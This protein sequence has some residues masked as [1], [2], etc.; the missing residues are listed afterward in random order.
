MGLVGWGPEVLR[1]L[2][3]GEGGGAGGLSGTGRTDCWMDIL[4]FGQTI[5]NSHLYSNFCITGKPC[6]PDFL[7]FC[8]SSMEGHY[9]NESSACLKKI[10]K[11]SLKK[12]AKN[13]ITGN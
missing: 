12:N 6:Y 11:K 1:G 3:P 13:I 4:T 10:S 7:P 8:M 2:G 9:A 5:G